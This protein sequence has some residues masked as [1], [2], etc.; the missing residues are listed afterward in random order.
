MTNKPFIFILLISFILSACGGGGGGGGSSAQPA[1]PGP[2]INFSS[3]MSSTV[4]VGTEYSFSWSTINA[5]TCSTSG[6]WQETIETSGSHSVT[7]DESKIYNFVLTCSSASGASSSKTKSVTSNFQLIGGIVFHQNN[8]NLTV[9]IDQNINGKLDSFEL[10]STSGSNGNYS[11]RSFDNIECLKDYPVRVENSYLFSI[12]PLEDKSNVNISSLTS[13]YEDLTYPI[14]GKENSDFFKNTTPCNTLDANELQNVKNRFNNAIELQKNLTQYTYEEIQQNP[15]STIAKP[16]ITMSRLQDV[17]DFYESAENL[18]TMIVESIK[19]NIDESFSDTGFSSNDFS[20]TASSSLSHYN[21]VIFLNDASY[22]NALSDIDL[23]ASSID[24]VALRAN[25]TF[26]IDPNSNVSMTNLNGWDEQAEIDL[27]PNAFIDNNARFLENSEWCW[28]DPS[29][30]CY[31]SIANDILGENAYQEYDS[32]GYFGLEKETSRGLE[33]IGSIEEFYSS[34]QKCDIDNMYLITDTLNQSSDDPVFTIDTFISR[35]RD[36]DIDWEGDCLE[37]MGGNFYQLMHSFTTFG[38]GSRIHLLWDS[39]N[40]DNLNQAYSPLSFDEDNLPPNQIPGPYI[41]AFIEKP[42]VFDQ[43][44][45]AYDINET[46]W[47]DLLNNIATE[48]VAT[49]E[50][51]GWSWMLYEVNNTKGGYAYLVFEMYSYSDVRARCVLNGEEILSTS[52]VLF[53]PDPFTNAAIV[54]SSCVT[55]EDEDENLI[56]SRF[57]THHKDISDRTV[58]PYYGEI[59]Y[60]EGNSSQSAH[61]AKKN[62]FLTKDQLRIENERTI[63]DDAH[64]D[65]KLPNKL[66]ID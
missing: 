11:I 13:L 45:H 17:D 29:S 41:D 7:L 4:D 56:F 40:I 37:W 22:P 42:R 47:Q 15:S 66:L 20:I 23:N 62:N 2:T 55:I 35:W 43:T 64:M 10:S 9:Y 50:E 31:L 58:S 19:N 6:D 52:W 27:G 60:Y 36:I 16:S 18:K 39:P 51:S 57:S 14:L 3:I 8:S 24:N 48:S 26:N 44:D 32:M 61:E 38:D 34:S 53:D 21:S 65:R 63:R 5:Q 33:A 59:P 12:N 30:Y 28:V 49:Y 54:L 25:F 46:N 1:N